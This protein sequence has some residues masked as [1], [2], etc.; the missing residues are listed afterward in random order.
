MNATTR[1]LPALLAALAL[2]AGVGAE[3]PARAQEA[4]PGF[5]PMDVFDLEAA[6]DPRISPDG[7]R[8]VYVRSWADVETDRQYSNLWMVGFEGS[9]HRPLTSGKHSEHSPRWSPSGDRILYVSDRD[10]STQVRIRWIDT[11]EDVAVTR[12]QTPPMNPAWSPDGTRIA[13]TSVVPGDDP[14]AGIAELPGPPEG[15]EWAP[16]ARVLDR[17]AHTFDGV[18]E[19]EPGYSHLFV[20]PAEG[21]TARQLSRGDFEHGG[22]GGRGSGAPVWSADGAH[23]LISANRR[24]DWET[25]P[26]DTEI[27]EFA[28]ADGS[29]RQLTDRRGPDN[30]VRVSPDGRR[31]AYTGYDD[32]YQGYQVT[33]LYVADRDG[34]SPRALADELDRSVGTL[35]WAPDG[36]AVYFTYDDQGNTK[37]GRVAVTG[38]SVRT[39]AG[40]VGSG[41]WAYSG[42]AAFTLSADG[43]RIAFTRTTPHVP[44]DVAAG[45]VEGGEHRVVT[46]LNEDLFAQ[47]A[48]GDVEEIWYESSHDGRRIQGWVVTPP[49]FDPDR[50]YPLILEIHGG[51]FANYGD[52]FDAEKQAMAGAG[53]LVLYM[54]PRG[55]TSYGEEFGNLI[56]HAYPG[57]D[58]LDLESGVDF[59]LE[60]DYVD[61]DRLFITGGSGGGVLSSWAIGKTDRYRAAVVIY[62]VINWYSWALTADM[63]ARGVKYW[64]PDTPWNAPEH[65]MERSS[66]SLVGNVTTPTLLITGEADHRTPMSETEQFYKALKLRDVEAALVKVPGESHGIHGRPSHFMQKIGYL[67]GWFDRY[68]SAERSAVGGAP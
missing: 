62:P 50:R 35:R 19:L 2:L 58:H 65:Y 56:H 55:S 38:G 61:P 29:I 25:E 39:V 32:R 34:G 1:I 51:P 44:G 5:Q 41:E 13:F 68:G 63:S 7:T 59:M 40:S 33:R 45:P 21:G 14:A 24:P 54:N 28:V 48:L 64:F 17:L 6:M 57:D 10:G 53:Y 22:G 8:I 43:T 37:I 42:G 49:D 66:I 4:A 11:G 12:T 36:S 27:Y 30:Q 15:A 31:I 18:G 60:R 52:R 3:V 46:S 26:G 23:V 16:P 20:V 67:I 9:G 47:R